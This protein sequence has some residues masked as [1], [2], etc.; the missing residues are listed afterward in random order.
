MKAKNLWISAILVMILQS[1]SAQKVETVQVPIESYKGFETTLTA[2]LTKYRLDYLKNGISAAIAEEEL[3]VAAQEAVFV[4]FIIDKEKVV[5]ALLSKPVTVRVNI[6]LQYDKSKDFSILQQA[7]VAQ[8]TNFW[9]AYAGRGIKESLGYTPRDGE[10]SSDVKKIT[11]T[12]TEEINGQ[13]KSVTTSTKEVIST[14]SLPQTVQTSPRTVSFKV[15]KDLEP[16]IN[17]LLTE[18]T[19]FVHQWVSTWQIR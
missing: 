2:A 11:T 7:Y 17:P 5:D 6:A 4:A 16:Y 3:V 19:K 13:T 18:V 15:P 1:V 12:V 10:S 14:S 8:M 9:N